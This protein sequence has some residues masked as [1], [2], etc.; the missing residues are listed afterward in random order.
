MTTIGV[1]S[2]G[3]MGGAIAAL[4]R[5]N[6][7]RV[8]TC[9]DGRS[10]RTRSLA[11]QAGCE[12]CASLEELVV[13]SEV[14]ISVLVPA[15]AVEVA[16][17][18]ARAIE[19]TGA[20]LLYVDANAIAPRT[21]R[22]IGEIVGRAGARVADVGIVGAPPRKPGTRFYTSGPAAEE[23]SGLGAYGLDVR[24]VGAELG[25]ASGFKMCYAALT[26]GLTAL[27]VELLLAARLMGLEEALRAEHRE[28]MSGILEWLERQVPSMPPK[29][30]RWVG[31]MEE[32]AQC[33]ADLGLTPNILLGAADMYRL[34]TDT[35]IG[36][37]TPENRDRSRD[38]DGVI[39]VLADAVTVPARN[40]K[41]Q[42]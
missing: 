35:P 42:A 9:L 18:V 22:E 26:K 19:A 15:R 14:L 20:N 27:G 17:D 3:D 36:R 34:V 23:F 40:Q 32:I 29:A 4:L 31:E 8:L 5:S 7:A 11:E 13:E 33:F 1:L 2:P 16:S 21:V 41:P 38:L 6:G 30:Y 28:S 24:I 39:A 37:E 12:V 10:E 25:Q